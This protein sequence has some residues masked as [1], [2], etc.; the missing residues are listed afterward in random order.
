MAGQESI[1]NN[2]N[3]QFARNEEM[4]ILQK[5][6]SF[7][8]KKLEVRGY[9]KEMAYRNQ[10]VFC[11]CGNDI[12]KEGDS[13][14]KNIYK[15]NLHG[16]AIDIFCELCNKKLFFDNS[17]K[18]KQ[19]TAPTPPPPEK[20][21]LIN[22]D[23]NQNIGNSMGSEKPKKNHDKK[24]KKSNEKSSFS[25]VK[26]LLL[27]ILTIIVLVFALK[28]WIFSPAPPAPNPPIE[29]QYN[30]GG[31][32]NSA[33]NPEINPSI[34]YL[35]S[36]EIIDIN[37]HECLFEYAINKSDTSALIASVINQAIN[38]KKINI[39]DL[40][41]SYIVDEMCNNSPPIDLRNEKTYKDLIKCVIMKLFKAK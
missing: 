2:T 11:S 32:A 20:Q 17:Q 38:F 36:P 31:N 9:V 24:G 22:E 18:A 5:V 16:N 6:L 14:L 26:K 19:P 8:E 13:E 30:E 4:T 41:E 40:G 34:E 7:I 3:S 39:L 27:S 21:P 29:V 1:F 12:Y 28:F 35:I 10:T 37:V 33:Q 23:T 25:S 15:K